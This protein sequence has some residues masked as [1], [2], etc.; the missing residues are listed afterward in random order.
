MTDDG[1]QAL[2]ALPLHSPSTM[3]VCDLD[4][5]Q[6]LRV[7]CGSCGRIGLVAAYRLYARC[8]MLQLINE[9]VP[10]LRCMECEKRDQRTSW[11]LVW[12]PEDYKPLKDDPA[13]TGCGNTPF[14]RYE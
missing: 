11:D 14:K 10:R 12:N 8:K 3:R 4:I 13:Y 5:R 1:I 6:A 9:V 2:N 7:T